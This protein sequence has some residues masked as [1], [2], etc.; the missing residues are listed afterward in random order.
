MPRIRCAILLLIFASSV[1][2][3]TVYELQSLSWFKGGSFS[4]WMNGNFRVFHDNFDD[5]LAPPNVPLQ[6]NPP[7]VTHYEGINIIS[8]DALRESDGTLFLDASLGALNNPINRRVRFRAVSNT[9][10]SPAAAGE[11]FNKGAS[12]AVRAVFSFKEPLPGETYGI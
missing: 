4:D 8:I 1:H 10:E 9:D 7:V 12:N 2:A 3:N 5:G 11:G 6:G